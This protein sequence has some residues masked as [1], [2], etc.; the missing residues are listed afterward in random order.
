MKLVL[1]VFFISFNILSAPSFADEVEEDDGDRI[2][3]GTRASP[4][5]IPY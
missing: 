3:G 1:L 4:G 2:I 5:E